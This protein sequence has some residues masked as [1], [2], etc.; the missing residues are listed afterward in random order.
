[1]LMRYLVSAPW[2]MKRWIASH[3]FPWRLYSAICRRVEWDVS[4]LGWYMATNGP[5]AGIHLQAT[6]TNHLCIP[7]GTYEAW[8]STWLV[9]LLTER[10]WGCS[11]K[12]VWDVG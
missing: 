6:H 2:P 5:Y 11:D 10:K 3:A 9:R 8:I 4:S 1:M 12:D 7:M